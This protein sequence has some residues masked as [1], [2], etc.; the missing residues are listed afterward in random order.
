MR[1]CVSQFHQLLGCWLPDGVHL[2]LPKCP[3]FLLPGRATE[4]VHCH[5]WQETHQQRP[6]AIFFYWIW[7]VSLRSQQESRCW[8]CWDVWD[9]LLCCLSPTRHLHPEDQAALQQPPLPV[10]QNQPGWHA[11]G[12]QAPATLPAVPWGPAGHQRLLSPHALQIQGLRYDMSS[13]HLDSVLVVCRI[14]DVPFLAAP[15]QMLEPVSLPGI[16]SCVLSMLCG[17]LNLLRG[18]HAIESVLQVL[19]IAACLSFRSTAV[20]EDWIFSDLID[21]LF[22]TWLVLKRR[23]SS[24]RMTTKTLITWWPSSSA[25]PPV[26]I[27]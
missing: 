22:S 1:D 13:R 7:W 15:S 18:V 4:R 8:A 19:E 20:M 26:C 2:K 9:I 5:L 6:A 3:G 11:D 24:H 27:R 25:R 23:L 21:A 17:G 10:H 14:S 12:D 16:V